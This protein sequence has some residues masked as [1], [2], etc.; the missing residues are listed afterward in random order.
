M[1]GVWRTIWEQSQAVLVLLVFLILWEAVCRAFAIPQWLLPPP[2]EV[3][4]KTWEIRGIL[5]EH[6]LPTTLAVVGGF[7]LSI[8]VGVPLAIAVVSSDL[9]RR[10]IY[11]M[12]LM[13]QS[14]P[15]VAIAPLLLLWV[16][17]GLAS[18]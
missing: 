3:A 2:S 7:A 9:L 5:P 18:N 6:I 11:P 12:L 14:V 17:Y 13:L 4:A 8:A 16:G 15:K 1:K 10:L